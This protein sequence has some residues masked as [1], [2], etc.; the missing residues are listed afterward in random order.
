M[1]SNTLGIARLDT[2]PVA[3]WRSENA[4]VTA[5]DPV[6]SQVLFTARSLTALV[7]CSREVIEDSVNL[8]EALT[9]ALSGA[10]A[11][12]L[13]RAVLFGSG[14]AP[15]PRGIFNTSGIL[16]VSMGTNG[17]AVT[18]YE[19]LLDALKLMQDNNN[20]DPTAAIMAPRTA[21]ALAG[22][23]DTTNQPLRLPPAIENLP[24]LVTS[25]VPVNQTQGTSN[26]ASTIILGD[27]SQCMIGV[28]T[29]FNIEVLRERFADNL[30]VAFLAYLRA[31]V[32]LLHPE[33]FVAI[34]G[35]L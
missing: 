1:T 8:T 19:P 5:S 32:Q 14:S 6:F 16:S 30:Q 7:K 21:R 17:A 35:V 20:A 28:R 4:A 24:R 18:N 10:F 22:L 26:A 27:Y 15:E 13:D 25:A 11:V 3:G 33:S 31:D 9:Q 23:K 2:D 12:E 29:K 34:K